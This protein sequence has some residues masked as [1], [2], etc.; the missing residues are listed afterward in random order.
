LKCTLNVS[1]GALCIVG[2]QQRTVPIR[3]VDSIHVINNLSNSNKGNG[4][5]DCSRSIDSFN[6]KH[7]QTRSPIVM[8]LSKLNLSLRYWCIIHGIQEIKYIIPIGSI[9][10]NETLRQIKKYVK[11]TESSLHE[12]K[13]IIPTSNLQISYIYF[14]I[15]LHSNV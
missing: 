14:K 12:S 1:Y 3:D 10:V 5:P 15:K 11:M 2:V 8:I 13:I 7:V 6:F 4:L 9:L